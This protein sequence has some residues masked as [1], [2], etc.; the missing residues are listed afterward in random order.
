MSAAMPVSVDDLE[1]ALNERL[2]IGHFRGP[3]RIHDVL[4]LNESD[5]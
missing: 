4:H 5:A 1:Q 2:D 3:S